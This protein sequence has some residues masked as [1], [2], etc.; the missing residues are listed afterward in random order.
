MNENNNPIEGN[1]NNPHGN[2][3]PLT[4]QSYDPSLIGQ[5]I[6]QITMYDLISLDACLKGKELFFTLFEEAM[7][8]N[9][10]CVT[11]AL[12]NN[13][14]FNWLLESLDLVNVCCEELPEFAKLDSDQRANYVDKISWLRENPE[15][16]PK[17]NWTDFFNKQTQE[18]NELFKTKVPELTAFLNNHFPKAMEQFL[19]DNREDDYED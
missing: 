12:N 18:V 2:Q 14:P 4:T 1:L 3:K 8:I 9:E 19:D 5:P 16:E 11:I 7:E 6:N 15:A 10:T 17:F 13:L